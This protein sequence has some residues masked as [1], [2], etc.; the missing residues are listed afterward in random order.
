M[1]IPAD[2][3][4]R[5]NAIFD[6]LSNETFPGFVAVHKNK[7]VGVGKGDGIE[8]IGEG[9]RVLDFKDKLIS[10]GLTDAHCFFNGWLLQ[11]IGPDL[12]RV[13]NLNEAIILTKKDINQ[14]LAI[15]HNLP[16]AFLPVP[17]SVMDE[18]FGDVPAVLVGQHSEGMAMNTAAQIVFGF[19][20][21]ECWSEKA[22]L[23]LKAIMQD[24]KLSIPL[25]QQYMAMM[26]SYGVTSTKEIGY[27]DFW[28]IEEVQKLEERG[29]LTLRVNLMSQPVG[30]P[31]N[32]NYGTRMRNLLA[33]NLMINFSGF[34]QMTDGSISQH[35]GEMK[36]SYLDFDGSCALEIDWSEL[37]RQVLM[38]DKEGMRFSLHTQ[39][40]G[41][42]EHAIDIFEKC[43][44]DVNGHVV[45]RH[46]M[47]DLEGADPV[48]YRRMADLGIT[49]EVYPLIQSIASRQEKISM[50]DQKI[51]KERGSH[52][53]NRR[54]ILDS[55]V[56]MACATDLPMTQDDLGMGVRCACAGLFPDSGIPF[57]LKN[58][59]TPGELLR[60]WCAGG[61]YDVN[62][63]DRL[64]TLEVGKL[65]DIAV[66]DNVLIA[67]N[68]EILDTKCY[69]TIVDGKIVYQR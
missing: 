57:N 13:W 11:N 3:V 32:I 39:G 60:S 31:A 24:T 44:R 28:F 56:T 20:P 69:L 47:T 68:E 46:A 1:N 63:E 16:L 2:I 34:N 61:A 36:E 55:G 33:N 7:I 48:D 17:T 19:T 49:A 45:N 35:E 26:N 42:V 65:A 8:F 52:Y 37:E 18:A 10:P 53:W 25:Y 4:L 9:T 51:G 67:D 30:E 23:L 58:M 27:D 66:F 41:A 64:G 62:Q 38:A 6:A 29:A 21:E 12:S 50:I 14:N 59:I 15:G 54:A 5:S 43:R 22:Y 40:D